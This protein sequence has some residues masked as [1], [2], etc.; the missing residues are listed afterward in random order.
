MEPAHNEGR[1][2]ILWLIGLPLAVIA[3]TLTLLALLSAVVEVDHGNRDII[4]GLA[5]AGGFGLPSALIARA[6][7]KG[8]GTLRYYALAGTVAGLIGFALLITASIW[9]DGRQDIVSS[10]ATMTWTKAAKLAAEV[11]TLAWP[12]AIAGL[13]GGTIFGGFARWADNGALTN[14][15]V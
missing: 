10:I 13:A 7:A 4:L 12:G 1:E 5:L 11:A 9:A 14:A 2:A 6:R 15:V 8:R 3:A